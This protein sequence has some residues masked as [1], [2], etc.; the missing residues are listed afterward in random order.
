MKKRLIAAVL[1]GV[2]AVSM[3]AGCGGSSDSSA[4]KSEPA[5]AESTAAEST[6]AESTAAASSA[7]SEETAA[8]AASGE[9]VKIGV[10]ISGWDDQ[11]LSYMLDCMRTY[12][13]E[14]SD[15]AEFQFTDGQNDN[16][17]QMGQ[18]EQFIADGCDAIIVNPVET[19]SSGPMVEA[20][21]A[22]GIPIIGVN[23]PLVGDYT[24]YCGGDSKQSGE[25]L[26]E[27][28]AEIADHKGKVVVLAGHAGQEAATLRTE[29]IEETIAKYPDM[30]IVE[31]QNCENW[32]RAKGMDIMNDWIQSGVEFDILLGECDEITIG[33]IMAMQQNGIDVSENGILAGGIDGSPDGLAMME[34]GAEL[35]DVFQDANGQGRGAMDLAVAAA[36]GETVEKE[37]PIPYE[38]ITPDK[39]QEYKDRW[40]SVTD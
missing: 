5:A 35:I 14:L 26:A 39:I 15:V 27:A 4:A 38:L 19:D 9:K 17:V 18:I 31:L 20:A 34:E 36:N 12:A 21:N 22:A 37:V 3:L 25:M 40:A 11:W 33:G 13:D 8:P 23:R 2:M 30:E 29:G 7:A 24:A 32:Q 28:I 10:S 16:G 1:T 6:A